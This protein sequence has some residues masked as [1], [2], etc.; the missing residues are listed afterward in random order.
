MSLLSLD[1]NISTFRAAEDE[2]LEPFYVTTAINYTNGPPHIG[3][4]YEAVTTDAIARYHRAY[5]P[6]E[7]RRRRR[8]PFSQASHSHLSRLR[9]YGRD[10][11]FLT[12]TDEHGQKVEKSAEALNRSCQ[13]HCDIYAKGFKDLNE[14]LSISNDFF[15]RTTSA[16]HEDLA[17]LVWTRVRERGDIYLE[18]YKGWYDL[19]AE[20]Y[21]SDKDAKAQGFK[22]DSGRD[23]EY[24]EDEESYFFKMSKYQDALLE[25]IDNHPHFI[26]PEARRKEILKFLRPD[27]DDD[28]GEN[29][30]TTLRD[31]CISRTVCKWGVKCPEDPD[32]K[33][34][35]EHVMYVWFDA[36][37]N[38]LSGVGLFAKD[39]AK[40][41]RGMKYWPASSHI[42]GKDI[43]RFHAVY[44]PTMLMSAQIPLPKSIYCHGFVND[45]HGKKM[46][47]SLGNVVE[48][49]ALLDVY[50]S[51]SFR[52]YLCKEAVY[53]GELSFSEEKLVLVHNATLVHNLGNLVRR[54]LS[55]CASY[56]DGVV[57]AYDESR[58]SS[59]RPGP[60]SIEDLKNTFERTMAVEGGFEI[61]VAVEAL[62]AATSETNKYLTDLAPWK[63][64]DVE[65]KNET[66]GVVL[67]AVYVLAH[68]FAVFCPDGAASVF[69]SL[70]HP[71]TEI[72]K[73]SPTFT[74][75]LPGT[76]T[77]VGDVMY[78]EMQVGVGSV[79]P[80]SSK[81]GDDFVDA[82]ARRKAE[83]AMKLAQ[84]RASKKAKQQA[85]SAANKKNSNPLD[86]NLFLRLDVRVGKITK[87]WEH[88]ESDKLYCE[89]IDV[90]EDEP[91]SIASGLR[92][93]Y[94]SPS[95]LLGKSVLVVCNLKVAK[96]AGFP[97]NGM[98]LCGSTEKK[99]EIVEPRGDVAVGTRV[100]LD[101]DAES[102]PAPFSSGQMKKKKTMPAVSEI[103]RLDDDGVAVYDGAK[104]AC[105]G[106]NFGCATLNGGVQIR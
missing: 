2:A 75:L 24:R 55:L 27:D 31:L 37:T 58:R 105:G 94:P 67:D 10:V 86:S 87:I 30:K 91:R 104:L 61:Q 41:A 20:Q 52:F 16:E 60:F 42:I 79:A 6:R 7:S 93:F 1:E 95:D 32:Y 102:W 29:S 25:H 44:W 8:S 3:H 103:L 76:K 43:V 38:Y 100:V 53:G 5:V 56:S 51:D 18:T 14:R 21:V 69:E 85:Q 45:S 81:A 97:S 13:T 70:A 71:P 66:V 54:S 78:S 59:A 89:E 26:Q 92:A 48:P 65:F 50:P 72:R 106:I 63:S 15:I 40:R 12:G 99:V 34:N 33:G 46:S 36:L 74:H 82:Q 57:P 88:P 96:L 84:A 19:G 77:T 62:C 90:G 68:F 83:N 11:F 35:K 101:L 28:D 4:A 49:N 22:D 47:K 98:V 23:L 9:R 17:R 64:K 73:L 39:P 80:P